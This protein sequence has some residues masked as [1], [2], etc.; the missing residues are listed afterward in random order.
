M[1]RG[2][3]SGRLALCDQ[4]IGTTPA[5]IVITPRSRARCDIP[6]RTLDHLAACLHTSAVW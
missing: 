5:L 2:D 4:R 1:G 3:A 6:A